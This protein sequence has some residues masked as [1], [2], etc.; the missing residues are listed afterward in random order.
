MENKVNNLED[1]KNAGSIAAQALKYGESLIKPGASLLE[2]SDMV[3]AKIIELGGEMAFPAQISCNQIAAHYCAEPDEDII[4]KDQLAC[5]DV[6]VHI[7]GNIGDN[8][9]TVDLSGQN[10]E[11]VK[12]SREALNNAIKIIRPGITLAEIGKTIQETIESFGFVPIRNLAGHGLGHY[13]IHTSPSIPNFDT[14]EIKE[15]EE[16]MVIAIEPFAT[17][18]AGMIYEGDR[19]NIFSMDQKRPTRNPF[20]REILKE[21]EKFKNLPFTTRWLTKKFHVAKVNS[22]LKELILNGTLHKYPP[23]SDRDK[24]LVSQAEHSLLVQDKPIILTKFEE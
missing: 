18:G 11:L 24:G 6:G 20:A 4:F 15:L 22:G 5:L 9:L 17:N 3:E 10:T 8:A 21:I 16:G 14:K 2:V 23:L 7:N 13:G 19:A 12:A 1:L